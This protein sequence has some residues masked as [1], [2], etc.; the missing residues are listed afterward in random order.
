[1]WLGSAALVALFVARVSQDLSR[2]EPALV[3]LPGFPR[4]P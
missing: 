1:M 3:P 2:E 4:T